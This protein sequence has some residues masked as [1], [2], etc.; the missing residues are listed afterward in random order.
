MRRPALVLA[1]TILSTS[2]GLGV[3][4]AET[5]GTTFPLDTPVTETPKFGYRRDVVVVDPPVGGEA[6]ALISQI[7]YLNRCTGGCDLKTGNDDD[8]TTNT[9]ALLDANSTLST[10]VHGDQ[11]WNDLMTCMREIYSPFDVQITDQRPPAGT[12]YHMA[13]VAGTSQEAGKDASIL[14][15]A[16]VRGDCAPRNNAVSLSFA[17]SHSP[18]SQLV[19]DLCHTVGQESA[20]AFGLDHSY[21]FSDGRSSCNDPMTYRSDCG[22]QRFFRNDSATCGEFEAR[23]CNCGSQQNSHAKILTVFGPNMGTPLIGPPTV[24]VTTPAAG[25]A[26]GPIVAANAGS[27]R[28]VAKVELLLNG[29]KWAEGKGAQFGLNG[30]PNPSPY[31]LT[32]PGN[33]PNSVI[34]VVVRACD[35]LGNCTNSAPVTV[36]KG[37]ACTT[38]DTC[39]K[40]QKCEGGKCFW[41]EPAGELGD[42]CTF[43]QFCKSLRCEGP[44][45][46]QVCSQ[47]CVPG[48][49]DSCPMG[50]QCLETGP[51]QGICYLESDDGGGCCSV[52]DDDGP[53]PWAI[54]GGVAALLLGLMLR[55]RRR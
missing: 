50:L 15:Q 34:D 29:F 38:A 1:S 16:I 27:K 45:D 12:Q 28:G 47:S 30:Q 6:P 20:H 10:F 44:V 24:Q 32:V 7:I 36:T 26:L 4:V 19:Y 2:A 31:S 53:A 8:A 22:G 25:G 39:A 14:G 23:A 11:V 40:G 17:N 13:I 37:M 3:A 5:S 42:P 55:R 54:H 41:D 48:T 35:D 9:S 33:V 46:A 49:G 52:G 21:A 51:A 43:P 18:G